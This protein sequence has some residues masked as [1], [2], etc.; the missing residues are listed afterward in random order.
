[1]SQLMNKARKAYQKGGEY[2]VEKF[3]Q[4]LTPN[5]KKQL[6]EETVNGIVEDILFKSLHKLQAELEQEMP[7]KGFSQN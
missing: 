6:L 1:M 7:F 3:I 5:E 2:E 4:S